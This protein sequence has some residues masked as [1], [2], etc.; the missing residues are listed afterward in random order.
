MTACSLL[1]LRDRPPVM[2][3]SAYPDSPDGSTC[4]ASFA[5]SERDDEGSDVRLGEGRGMADGRR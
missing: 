4:T 1:C 2:G 3:P 5:T